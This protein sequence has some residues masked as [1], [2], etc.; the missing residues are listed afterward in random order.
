MQVR[1]N[2]NSG[3][4]VFERFFI[5]WERVVKIFNFVKRNVHS[6]I[7]QVSLNIMG[8]N[9][10]EIENGKGTNTNST[11]IRVRSVEKK[12]NEEK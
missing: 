6:K 3:T 8:I 7:S 4:E 1:T 2:G 9:S 11:P 12:W 10:K 5:I